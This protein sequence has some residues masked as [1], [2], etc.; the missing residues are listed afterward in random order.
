MKKITILIALSCVLFFL[1]CENK[2]VKKVAEK[3]INVQ[4]QP[5]K[6]KSLRPFINNIGTLI[7]HEEVTVSSE[8]DGVLKDVM[9]DNGTVVSKG[10]VLAVIDDT[11]YSLEVER[12]NAALKQAE[13]NLSNIKIEY[14]RKEDL[15]KKELLTKQQYDDVSAR[16]SIADA[17][18]E[19]AKASLSTSRQR[20]SKTKIYST[21]SGVIKEKMASAGNYVKNGTQLFAV[22]QTNPIKL[23][24]TVTEKDLEKIK[25]G[26]DVFLTVYAFPDREFKGK[27]NIIYPSIDERTR[28]VRVEALVPNAEGLLMPGFF[29]KVMLYI[30][31][32]KDIILVPVTSLLYEEDKIKVFVVEGDKA[33]ERF[34][35]IGQKFKLQSE[36]GS[37]E[38]DLEEYAEVMKGLKEGEQIVSVGQQNLFEGAKIKIVAGKD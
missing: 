9:A 25:K 28:T 22:I 20:L 26:Q 19:R 11:D 33:K 24:F 23:D 36:G 10:M 35:K 17:E 30:G 34:V 27:L 3:V 16:L 4:V 12:A 5:V 15:Y 29:A 37:Q 13:A 14:Q 38:S 8:V 6:K 1:G 18:L 7:P 31:D 21:L 2:E 32:A